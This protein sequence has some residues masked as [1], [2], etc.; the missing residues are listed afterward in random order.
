MKSKHVIH[1][2]NLASLALWFAFYFSSCSAGLPGIF[3]SPSTPG[4]Q[5]AFTANQA[6]ELHE[7]L[8][9]IDAEQPP[10]GADLEIYSQ[11]KSE[12]K[13][14]LLSRNASQIPELPPEGEYNRVR[15]IRLVEN[16]PG[17]YALQ[18]TYVNVGDSNQD[19]LVSISD[20]TP[21]GVYFG[22]RLGDYNW[23]QAQAADTNSDGLVTINDITPIGANYNRIIREYTIYRCSNIADIPDNNNGENGPGSN[24]I[25]V[26]PF[27][28]HE[29]SVVRTTSTNGGRPR[30]SYTLDDPPGDDLFWVRPALGDGSTEGVA[31]FAMGDSDSMPTLTVANPPTAGS[32]TE[33]N[34]YIVDTATAFT[35][36]LVDP[37]DGEVTADPETWYDSSD[38]YAGWFEGNVLTA[39]ADYFG[40]FYVYAFYGLWPSNNVYFEIP[41]QGGNRPPSA[42]PQQIEAMQDTPRAITLT[43]GDP[44]GDG[45]TF[46]ISLQ[47]SPGSL[48]DSQLPDVSYTP[49]PGYLGPD[50]FTFTVSDGEFTSSPATVSITVI[51]QNDPPVVQDMLVTIYSDEPANMLIPAEDPDDD[52]LTFIITDLPKKG[53]LIADAFPRVIYEPSGLVVTTDAFTYKVNDGIQ[54][55]NE[56]IVT[57]RPMAWYA[58]YQRVID[59]ESLGEDIGP[60]VL[61]TNG[62]M[63]F[64]ANANG[65]TDRR[66]YSMNID[67][68]NLQSYNIPDGNG[69]IEAVDCHYDG[70]RAFFYAPADYMVYKLENS[71][72]T[73]INLWREEDGPGF[74][75]SNFDALDDG[76]WVYFSDGQ[77]IWKIFHTGVSLQRAINDSD[78][79][80]D[81]GPGCMV[82]NFAVSA[83]GSSIAFILWGYLDGGTPVFKPDIFNWY[84]TYGIR[85]ST[86][87]GNTITKGT[88]ELGIA[89]NDTEKLENYRTVY[90][91]YNGES[92]YYSIFA[93]GSD[94]TPLWN[95]GFNYGGMNVTY[96]GSHVFYRDALA[97]GGRFAATDG[98]S[99]LELF[100]PWDVTNITLE[101]TYVMGINRMESRIMFMMGGALYVGYIGYHGEYGF[102]KSLGSVD[103]APMIESISFV[104]PYLERGNPDARV[105]MTVYVSDPD[106]QSD[107]TN[108]ANDEML[109]GIKIGNNS[110]PVPAYFYAYPRDDGSWPDLVANDGFWTTQGQPGGE[111]N[112]LD[113]VTIR[114]A[115]MDASRTVVVADT[116][117]GI[118]EMAVPE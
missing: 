75:N 10:A 64:F 100:P 91:G 27:T 52:E 69:F 66:V 70:C 60:A 12:L 84:I 13:R 72:I 36:N 112:S 47:P 81:G 50:S 9:S 23:D 108:M 118:N 4:S 94:K 6:I 1:G 89:G 30:F 14:I 16:P 63:I 117:L 51:E 18:W 3:A 87:D 19:S 109:E 46:A 41:W 37:D 59:S 80:R 57:I 25:A 54:D 44:D 56:A 39:D 82:Q 103:D 99:I 21:L 116:E 104:P 97:G 7:T 11:L 49:G 98:S 76:Q 92:R 8:A 105:M 101:A 78:V 88:S 96:D 68:S 113:E 40:T 90:A 42:D 110:E 115:A 45:L 61:S 93:D 5:S 62:E 65:W 102:L 17:T 58:E 107:I 73:G 33:A 2:V 71:M 95:L 79:D 35:F 20:I 85:Q 55:S 31:S 53:A 34:P 28:A 22:A 24:K 74:L 29:S 83:D 67:G 106:G 43:G 114:I 38:V 32:G 15:S 86:F 111:I 77:D 26:V 48:D